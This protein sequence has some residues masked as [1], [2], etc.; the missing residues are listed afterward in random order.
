MNTLN[1]PVQVQPRTIITSWRVNT[2][3]SGGYNLGILLGDLL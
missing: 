1:N 2:L 3:G